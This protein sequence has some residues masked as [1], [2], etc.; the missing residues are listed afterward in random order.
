[1]NFFTNFP[2]ASLGVE[3]VSVVGINDFEGD[4]LANVGEL[5]VVINLASLFGESYEIN[6]VE[7]NNA[8]LNAILLE[9]GVANWDIVLSDSTET[10]EDTTSSSAFKLALDD[11]SINNLSVSYDDRMDSLFAAVKGLN[12]QLAG[13][14]SLDMQALANIENFELFI[15][16][17]KI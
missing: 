10:S 16:Y 12:L 13:D 15:N 11:F 7:L 2:N 17:K 14:I 6:E 8:S 9:N 4:T 5:N 1:M 3:N